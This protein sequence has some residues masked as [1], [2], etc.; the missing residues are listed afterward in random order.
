M[1]VVKEI[2]LLHIWLKITCYISEYQ[3]KVFLSIIF[4]IK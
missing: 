2:D 4:H 1:S 3:D